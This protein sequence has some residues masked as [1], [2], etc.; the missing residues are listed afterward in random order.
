MKKILY[1]FG[2]FSL[3]NCV[4]VYAAAKKSAQSA[5]HHNPTPTVRIFFQ[6]GGAGAS[7]WAQGMAQW[8]AQM[9]A[10]G[11][12]MGMQAQQFA[13][14]QRQAAQV[15]MQA[16]A[17][18]SAVETSAQAQQTDAS[19]SSS[20]R[21]LQH[22]HFET[23]HVQIPVHAAPAAAAEGAQASASKIHIEEL[24]EAFE[25]NFKTPKGKT[26]RLCNDKDCSKDGKGTPHK[27]FN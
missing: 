20:S 16:A 12:Q 21:P 26:R 23:M 13:A 11:A 6:S 17:A 25:V 3:V 4:Y 7:Q 19:Q 2:F 10:W 14:Q 22:M 27:H 8:G 18:A 24:E 1:L 15:Q 5:Q 9:G